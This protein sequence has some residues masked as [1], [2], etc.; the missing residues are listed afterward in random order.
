MLGEQEADKHHATLP[1]MH[2]PDTV[3][4]TDAC[5]LCARRL[6]GEDRIDNAC[7]LFYF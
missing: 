7:T 1:A 6:A 3:F 4:D 2:K 5:I